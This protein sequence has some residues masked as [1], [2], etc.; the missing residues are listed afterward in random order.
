MYPFSVSTVVIPGVEISILHEVVSVRL[1]KKE[2]RSN[3]HT[4]P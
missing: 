4:Y 1:N 2:K 3:V